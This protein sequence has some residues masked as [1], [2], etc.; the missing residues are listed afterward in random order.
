MKIRNLMIIAFTIPAMILLSGCARRI[1][2][3]TTAY[4]DSK[5]IPYGFGTN[6]TFYLEGESYADGVK[7]N[8]N[9]LET[10][11]LKNKISTM[12]ENKGHSVTESNR[13][14]Y[15]LFFN[16]GCDQQTVTYDVL[17]YMPGPTLTSNSTVTG[18][19]GGR[20]FNS[21]YQNTTTTPGTFY[22]APEQRTYFT[23]GLGIFIYDKKGSEE[24]WKAYSVGVDEY[25]DLRTF[26][27]F[28]LIPIFNLF[29]KSGE[30][31]N[32][33]FEDNESVDLL[34]KQMSGEKI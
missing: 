3:K 27:D 30:I 23:K 7:Q 5:V 10:K 29:G 32:T 4:A 17:R 16:H 14:D 20:Y 19:A 6:K 34:R 1:N 33:M 11:E 25:N 2:I 8:N 24:I 31:N 12:L 28:L 22:W 26:L 21:Q 18:T 13:A 15:L 9:A